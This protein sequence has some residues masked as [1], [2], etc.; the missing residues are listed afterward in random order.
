M[1]IHTRAEVAGN[2]PED[3]KRGNSLIRASVIFSYISDVGY[4]SN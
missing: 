1:L 2:P 4:L 3:N